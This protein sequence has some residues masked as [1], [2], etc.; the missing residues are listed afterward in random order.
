MKINRF[1]KEL[2]GVKVHGSPGS[3][4]SHPRLQ[5]QPE[6]VLKK[7]KQRISRKSSKVM[8]FTALGKVWPSKKQ[9]NTMFFAS[10]MLPDM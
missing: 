2:N 10:G 4:P 1:L 7:K 5:A 6:R 9:E 8:L 3:R